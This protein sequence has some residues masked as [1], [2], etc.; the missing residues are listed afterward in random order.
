MLSKTSTL[1]RTMSTTRAFSTS[2]T[3]GGGAR[4]MQKLFID[5]LDEA[6]AAAAVNKT[7]GRNVSS[8]SGASPACSAVNNQHTEAAVAAAPVSKPQQRKMQKLFIE[9]LDEAQAKIGARKSDK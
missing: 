6:Q 9:Y 2:T 1:L 3:R 8:S 7:G 5:Y 4:K